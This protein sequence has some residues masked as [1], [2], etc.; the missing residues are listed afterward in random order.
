MF[1]NYSNNTQHQEGSFHVQKPSSDFTVLSCSEIQAWTWIWCLLFSVKLKLCN[2]L[3]VITENNMSLSNVNWKSTTGFEEGCKSV[4][5]TY[6][7]FW[8][9]LQA[10]VLLCSA[11]SYLLVALIHSHSLT[12]MQANQ[13]LSHSRSHSAWS[14]TKVEMKPPTTRSITFNL[15]YTNQWLS[16]KHFPSSE[17]LQICF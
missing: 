14:S 3:T 6:S 16:Q 9:S 4:T 1:P 7:F 5:K 15:H 17:L 2:A 12:L 8:V 11:L 10:T 13:H